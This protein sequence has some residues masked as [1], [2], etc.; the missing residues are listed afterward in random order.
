MKNLTTNV[1]N[2]QRF[3]FQFIGKLN[4]FALLSIFILAGCNPNF[5]QE[6]SDLEGGGQ[7]TRVSGNFTLSL[8]SAVDPDEPEFTVRGDLKIGQMVRLYTGSNCQ[9]LRDEKK[10]TNNFSVKLYSSPLINNGYYTYKIKVYN[11]EGDSS[12][13]LDTNVKYSFTNGFTLPTP[14]VGISSTNIIRQPTINVT[15][16]Q[17][18]N[19][20]S[21]YTDANCTQFIGSA[22]AG[23]NGEANLVPA[24]PLEDGDYRFYAKTIINGET[25]AC[26][27]GS[28]VLSIDSKIKNPRLVPPIQETDNL[29]TIQVTLENVIEDV[30]VLVYDTNDCS[31]SPMMVSP[32][33][34]D[35]GSFVLTIGQKPD[36]SY[37]INQEKTYRFNFRQEKYPGAGFS[38]LTPCSSDQLVYEYDITPKNPKIAAGFATASNKVFSPSFQYENFNN[39]STIR[40]FRNN[41]CSGAPLVNYTYPGANNGVLTI[42][43]DATNRTLSGQPDGTYQYTFFQTIAGVDSKCSTPVSYTI[44]TA[45]I[46]AFENGITSPSSNPFP[47]FLISNVA[48]DQNI[49]LY[50]SADCT[51]GLVNSALYSQTDLG[52]NTLITFTSPRTVTASGEDFSVRQIITDAPNA[53]RTSVCSNSLNYH[54]NSS[55]L[56]ASFAADQLSIDRTSTPK[57]TFSNTLDNSDIHIFQDA[58]DTACKN[59]LSA[60][61]EKVPTGTNATVDYTVTTALTTDGTFRYYIREYLDLQG[62][63]DYYS[64]C[65]RLTYRR[66]TLPKSLSLNGV[67]STD[68]RQFPGFKV[69]NIDDPNNFELI[70]SVDNDCTTTGDNTT[71]P[72]DLANDSYNSTTAEWILKSTTALPAEGGNYYFIRNTNFPGTTGCSNS[73]YYRLKVTPALQLA[74][75]TL[76]GEND[77]LPEVRFTNLIDDY[78]LHYF[79]DDDCSSNEFTGDPDFDFTGAGGAPASLE[80]TLDLRPLVTSDGTYQISA[81]YRNGAFSGECK[82][83]NYT[84]DGKIKNITRISPSSSTSTTVY[85]PSYRFNGLIPDTQLRLY[86]SKADCDAGSNIFTSL[87]AVTD[88]DGNDVTFSFDITTDVPTMLPTPISDQ[89]I[90]VWAKQHRTSNGYNS[91]CVEAPSYEMSA[92]PVGLL[93]DTSGTYITAP[94]FAI[95]SDFDGA[96]DVELRLFT[97]DTCST[98]IPVTGGNVNVPGLGNETYGV[99]VDYDDANLPFNRSGSYEIY[100]Q[101]YRDDPTDT[102]FAGTHLSDCTP[103]PVRYVF[104]AT[105]NNVRFSNEAIQTGTT[106]FNDDE[107]PVINTPTPTFLVDN[108]ISGATVAL[109]IDRRDGAGATNNQCSEAYG[110][111]EADSLYTG[112]GYRVEQGVIDGNGTYTVYFKQMIGDYNDDGP[113]YDC[114][115]AFTFQVDGIPDNIAFADSNFSNDIRVGEKVWVGGSHLQVQSITNDTTAILDG[116]VATPA[117]RTR[118]RVTHDPS[119]LLTG[120]IGWDGDPA[121]TSQIDGSGTSFT[122]DIRVGDIIFN[123]GNEYYVDQID[124]NTQLQVITTGS[125]TPLSTDATG[126]LLP[127]RKHT[128][129]NLTGTISFNSGT[130]TTE[131]TGSGSATFTT[132]VGVGDLLLVKARYYLVESVTDD[133]TLIVSAS[134]PL[135]STVTNANAVVIRKVVPGP[136][137]VSNVTTTTLVVGETF[138]SPGVDLAPWIVVEG[139]ADDLHAQ[140][141]AVSDSEYN[142]TPDSICSD[143]QAIAISDYI[144]TNI[145]DDSVLN[146]EI[147]GSKFT[148]FPINDNNTKLL[149]DDVYYFAVRLVGNDV[150]G[151][152]D[153]SAFNECTTEALQFVL[154]GTPSDISIK[155]EDQENEDA[156]EIADNDNITNNHKPVF[157]Y[158]NYVYLPGYSTQHV[159]RAFHGAGNQA[160]ALADCTADDGTGTD[161]FSQN[162]GTT[163]ETDTFNG[164]AKFT[165]DGLYFVYFKQ[166]H[167]KTGAGDDDYASDCLYNTVSPGSGI[168]SFV[169]DGELKN[170]TLIS[171][172]TNEG[173]I[174]DYTIQVENYRKSAG[175]SIQ[176]F[177]DDFSGNLK[178]DA[179]LI[180]TVTDDEITETSPGI[181]QFSV[182]RLT[183]SIDVN[184]TDD[185][186]L[187]FRQVNDEDGYT[188]DCT[189]APVHYDL[190]APIEATFTNDSTPSDKTYESDDPTPSITI[191]LA[192]TV[193]NDP[194]NT[195]EFHLTSNCGG[196][197]IDTITDPHNNT[198]D[199]D[200]NKDTGRLNLSGLSADG[201]YDIYIRQVLAE[202]NTYTGECV[203]P[204]RYNL[205]Y[206]NEG[207][208]VAFDPTATFM[209]EPAYIVTTAEDNM[210]I[211]VYLNDNTCSAPNLVATINDAPIGDNNIGGIYLIEDR[212]PHELFF[213]LDNDAGYVSGCIQ[214]ASANP[215]VN[216]KPSVLTIPAGVTSNNPTPT[217]EVNGILAKSSTDTIV[218]LHLDSSCN[219]AAIGT[220]TTAGESITDGKVQVTTNIFTEDNVY[221]IFAKQQHD[222]G[223]DGYDVGVDYESDCSQANVTYT[224]DGEPT[225]ITPTGST[226]TNSTPTNLASPTY[227][228]KNI[229]TGH[230]VDAYPSKVDC[231]NGTR[232]LNTSNGSLTGDQMPITV[233]LEDDGTYKLSFKQRNAADTYQSECTDEF[234]YNLDRR[235][236]GV[237]FNNDTNKLQ[238]VFDV[239]GTDSALDDI[240]IYT[241]LEDGG[242]GCDVLR[243]IASAVDGTTTVTS[244]NNPLNLDDEYKFYARMVNASSNGNI[245]GTVSFNEA[246]NETRIVGSGTTFTSLLV[247]NE[248]IISGKTYEIDSI[249]DDT[250]LHVL[251]GSFEENESVSGVTAESITI[252]QTAC[253]DAF[254]T[255]T[256]DLKPNNIT[257][258]AGNPSQELNPIVYINDILPGARVTFYHI[259]DAIT[260]FD[261]FADPFGCPTTGAVELGSGD[262]SDNDGDLDNIE[263]TTLANF[264]SGDSDKIYPIY[265]YQFLPGN[266]F[267]SKCNLLGNYTLNMRPVFESNWRQTPNEKD[268]VVDIKLDNLIQGANI[269]V[270][271]DSCHP[272]NILSPIS[273]SNAVTSNTGSQTYSFDLGTDLGGNLIDNTTYRFFASQ[274]KDGFDSGCTTL[275]SASYHYNSS[276]NVTAV[277]VGANPQRKPR[278]EISELLIG[279]PRNFKVYAVPDTQDI[280]S[281]G[282]LIFD[283]SVSSAAPEV[284]GITNGLMTVLIDLNTHPQA[285]PFNSDANYTFR[286]EQT[287]DSGRV[288]GC[289]EQED[290]ATYNLDSKPVLD[291]MT[292]AGG[293]GSDQFPTFTLQSNPMFDSDGYEIDVYLNDSD[294]SDAAFVTNWTNGAAVD[295]SGQVAGFTSNY[296]RFNFKLRDPT[297]EHATTVCSDTVIYDYDALTLDL[298]TASPDPNDDLSPLVEVSNVDPNDEIKL[299]SDDSCSNLIATFNV[300]AGA[301]ANTTVLIETDPL[302]TDGTIQIH[303]TRKP[304]GGNQTLCSKDFVEY[305]IDIEPTS[306]AFSGGGTVG[307]DSTPTFDLTGVLDNAQINLY[308]DANCTQL[309]GIGTTAFGVTNV[310]IES[311]ELPADGA[312]KFHIVQIKASTGFTSK[313]SQTAADYTLIS[314]P[315][316]VSLMQNNPSSEAQPYLRVDGVAE[317]STVRLFRDTGNGGDG[318]DTEIGSATSTG[319]SIDVQ[320]NGGVLSSTTT[321]DI[322]A[323]HEVGAVI[324]GCSDSFVTY[325]FDTT[326]TDWSVDFAE[327]FNSNT[328]QVGNSVAIDENLMVIGEPEYNGSGTKQGRIRILE[329]NAG[330]WAEVA[331]TQPGDIDDQDRFGYAVDVFHNGSNV[332]YI[333]A[334]APFH[335]TTAGDDNRGSVYVFRYNATIDSLSQQA[336][337][338]PVD[339]EDGDNIGYAVAING[340]K[341]AYS[342]VT[343][344]SNKGKIYYNRSNTGSYDYALETGF[345]VEF[346]N[347]LGGSSLS[348]D[349]DY[350]IA[351]APGAESVLIYDL[352]NSNVRTRLQESTVTVGHEFGYAVSHNG[353]HLLVGAPGSGTDAG[354]AVIYDITD[355][356]ATPLEIT[357]SNQANNNRFGQKVSLAKTGNYAAI[358][359]P[360]TNSSAGKAYIFQGTNFD[361]ETDVTA[362]DVSTQMEYGYSVDFSNSNSEF[363]IS[364]PASNSSI[365]NPGVYIHSTP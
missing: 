238:P 232:K 76:S 109:H 304:A 102:L 155:D 34:A 163:N 6:V 290:T 205:V 356:N 171:P 176:V 266:T 68:T 9:T 335:D 287:L 50:A 271:Y 158:R 56:G 91:E 346:T 137:T 288:S 314:K 11:R 114:S 136:V 301:P 365:I 348:L 132:E 305:E 194:Q 347:A 189:L 4:L 353:T 279:G 246:T 143:P 201:S 10:V 187:W 272:D 334:S 223:K 306:F 59:P 152:P 182:N 217:I 28:T 259:D 58:D 321:L 313:C 260:A 330:K 296:V 195:I 101:V 242:D 342:S 254:A 317:N 234:T 236:S 180:D 71:M 29:N 184:D 165:A 229:F 315:T 141:Y 300:S 292:P 97:D 44:N 265:A 119:V 285:F 166:Y 308:R 81:Q 361:V 128:G 310:S 51:T 23:A 212:S 167:P 19:P 192:N 257:F 237:A 274:T 26:S 127:V 131:V 63:D 108:L 186:Y 84:I 124:S 281:G 273:G 210:D 264:A 197:P 53:N 261:G 130:S 20:V 275:S 147:S 177:N 207:E 299:Y 157:Q 193:I 247:G 277:T 86:S 209:L 118:L 87:P 345:P 270:Y 228:V 12:P 7:S 111:S 117:E 110:A 30:R 49:E 323:R 67:S 245:A 116:N 303:A 17:Q 173:K 169:L 43:S 282:T 88:S 74:S 339:P 79:F 105:P 293:F 126:Q 3:D 14:S 284:T 324:G 148:T 70:R 92:K 37:H 62:A 280:C 190:S 185:I 319:T 107:I 122:S 332:Y 175:R 2:L 253:S 16:A 244:S 73:V 354:R 263:N 178:C 54:V 174:I 113:N 80:K 333:V 129:T 202:A 241:S 255:Y 78:V 65:I 85:K 146:V 106:T 25:I 295:I 103:S 24:V 220:Q 318:C 18:G 164:A 21:F 325:N 60:P 298:I 268:D 77:F 218:T 45:P 135:T 309:A 249:T 198:G 47:K 172:A 243:G 31:S 181:F 278:I 149:T 336:V 360:G 39:T 337:I 344:D 328:T 179:T 38:R 235:P 240:R 204:H 206:A 82:A 358:S 196:A 276:P 233:N 13:C 94:Y 311:S 42:P 199:T 294:C 203:G 66:E 69:N 221:T 316:K 90:T 139:I 55:S 355:L 115:E 159:F 183:D 256:L 121:P 134:T 219:N 89:T 200:Y 214:P 329:K 75:G 231:Q 112:N 291:S 327:R 211:N 350:L 341:L 213:Q 95:F 104:D 349:D 46:L 297:G 93:A 83:I 145:L 269:F 170:P 142:G 267:A 32:V 225:N 156:G 208:F 352:N 15:G 351:G 215:V 1:L 258:A 331:T 357:D 230:I 343:K 64:D 338:T 140:V 340:D 138:T 160:T 251:P 150:N 123:G 191:D 286:A 283:G 22:N 48:S 227:T 362:F 35:P 250:E 72:I 222:P 27:S 289:Y 52:S 161:Y 154:E 33:V 125:S 99:L 40:V 144:D 100:A 307:L 57:F 8:L 168:Y 262:D 302:T 188:S 133:D 153:S 326:A 151:D 5:E 36:T 248:L 162:S 41:N 239:S 312:Y 226:P 364:A 359:A 224:L 363:V 320:I 120:S 252:E 98:S 61:E 96:T 322:Y 216:G